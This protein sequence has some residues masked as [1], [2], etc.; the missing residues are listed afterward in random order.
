[1][2]GGGPHIS[3]A[4][5]VCSRYFEHISDGE[6]QTYVYTYDYQLEEA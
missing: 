2:V 3:R 1:M 5:E 6:L 4:G